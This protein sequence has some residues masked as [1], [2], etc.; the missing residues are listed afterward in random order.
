MKPHMNQGPMDT[1]ASRKQAVRIVMEIRY[2]RCRVPTS[3][4]WL[5]V[6]VVIR[7]ASG[8]LRAMTS[9]YA[10]GRRHP[11]T[12][13][14]TVST[15]TIDGPV[16][17]PEENHDRPHVPRHRD[18][19]YLTRGN[20]PGHPQRHLARRA[21]VAPRRLV[22]GHPG[23]RPGQGRSG[24]ALPG[25]P[26]AWLPPRGRLTGRPPAAFSGARSDSVTSSHPPPCR[27]NARTPTLGWT[28]AF[29]GDRAAF[30][31]DRAAIPGDRAAIP[32]DRAR[33]DHRPTQGVIPRTQR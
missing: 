29:P 15:P 23:P 24:R 9:P 21:D 7:M 6:A 22:R 17:R 13:P 8:S 10:P 3:A 11:R 19:R 4:L 26:Q 31:G 20:R 16:H 12:R 27:T 32:G 25:G 30:P 28:P 2:R 33:R 14:V 5:R 18:R 1:T